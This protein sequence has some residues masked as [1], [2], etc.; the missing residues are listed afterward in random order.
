MTRGHLIGCVTWFCC[1]IAAGACSSRKE[2]PPPSAAQQTAPAQPS[3]RQAAPAGQPSKPEEAPEPTGGDSQAAPTPAGEGKLECVLS[4]PSKV[5]PGKPVELTFRLTNRTER[6]L[7]VLK[8]HTP[9]E[10]FRANF[11]TVT[12]DGSG[13][14][15]NGPMM[16]RAAPS[17]DD[18]ATLAPGASVEARFNVS[19]AYDVSAPASY[20]F[21]L[22]TD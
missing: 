19:Q 6:P 1:A 7:Y 22:G 2:A 5:G 3:E 14:P 10:G 15:Y 21:A 17:K 12:R 11:L 8:W 18:Y 9:L 16:K 13:V 4:G 20:Q